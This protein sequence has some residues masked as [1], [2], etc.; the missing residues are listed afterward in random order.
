MMMAITSVA[1]LV[2]SSSVGMAS[3]QLWANSMPRTAIQGSSGGFAICASAVFELLH[4]IACMH[5]Y[6]HVHIR[7]IDTRLVFFCS[8]SLSLSISRTR[9]RLSSRSLKAISD[10]FH[11][12]DEDFEEKLRH[13]A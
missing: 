11:D 12:K 1:V 10:P 2:G 3:S 13:L 4:Y 5:A 7:I 8:F 6:I 9:P